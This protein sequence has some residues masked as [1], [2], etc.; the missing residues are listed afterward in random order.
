MARSLRAVA[1]SSANVVKKIDYD[2]FGNIVTETYEEFKVSFGFAGGMHDRDARLVRFG[3]KN[4]DPDVGRWTGKDPTVFAGGDADLYGY[5][6]SNPV[7]F[8]DPNA[9][10]LTVSFILL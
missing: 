9:M 1:D 2:S 7:N 5:C 10:R 4:Y 3:L 6:I 8:I